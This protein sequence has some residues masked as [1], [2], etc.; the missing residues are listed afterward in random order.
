MDPTTLTTF[1]QKALASGYTPKQVDDFIQKKMQTFATGAL[2]TGGY[3]PFGDYAKSDPVNALGLIQSGFQPNLSKPEDI[4]KARALSSRVNLL[5]SYLNKSEAS[6][7]IAGRLLNF[8]SGASTGEIGTNAYEFN[9]LRDSLKAP[10]A[11]LISGESG[12]LNEGDI[13]RA[14]G[15][16]PR[17][18]ESPAIRAEKLRTLKEALATI[19]GNR[20]GS[21]YQGDITPGQVKGAN[22]EAKQG[23]GFI[24][25][26]VKAITD[27][28]VGTGKTIA[29]AAY[30][31]NRAPGTPRSKS[32]FLLSEDELIAINKDPVGF[33]LDQAGRSA[34]IA[35]YAVPTTQGTSLFGRSLPALGRVKGGALAGALFGAGKE[36]GSNL[37]ARGA[38]IGTGAAFGALIGWIS[39]KIAGK[40]APT[41]EQQPGAYQD[42]VETAQKLSPEVRA[43]SR[44]AKAGAEITG[45]QY[46]L[47]RN[48]AQRLH[49]RET[50]QQLDDYGLTHI[51]KVREAVPK[52]TGSN[53]IITKL[54][55]ESVGQAQPVNMDGLLQMADEIA[56]DPSLPTGVDTKFVNFVKKGITNLPETNGTA[57][58]SQ[59]GEPF[60]TFSFIQSLEKK[61]ADLVRPR[62]YSVVQQQDVALSNAYRL[63]A[64]ELKLRLFSESGADNAI[65]NLVN[66]PTALNQLKAVSPKLAEQARKVTTV[67]QLRSLAA[68]FVRAGQAIDMTD[69]GQYLAFNSLVD[70][71]N[72]AGNL[73]SKPLNIVTAP[74]R[75]NAVKSRLGHLLMGGGASLPNIGIPQ[76]NLPGD[77]LLS[78]LLLGATA[79]GGQSNATR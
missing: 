21:Q 65:V 71:V 13:K 41:V 44:L 15:L 29:T 27:P 53:G 22:T 54:T 7:P 2:A 79:G 31:L 56:A 48:A 67:G 64:D 76:P 24:K 55:R 30:E 6:G 12:V 20:T 40:K 69:A 39:S 34:A 61:A 10:L 16:L 47:P 74:L 14:E 36:T 57:I 49:M 17:I 4:Q 50:I 60:K 5:E 42:T 77:A 70:A 23:D 32:P 1:K 52:V 72:N 19:G 66:N 46:N 8:L 75:T 58:Q 37:G 35:A 45:Q 25:S 78:K 38:N 62:A 18:E 68:P 9:Q 59:F 43:N 33:L 26:V 3:I 51:D 28:F 63:F 11:R 73:L